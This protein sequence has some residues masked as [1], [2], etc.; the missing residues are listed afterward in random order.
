MMGLLYN[1]FNSYFSKDTIRDQKNFKLMV[2]A[3]VGGQLPPNS[4]GDYNEELHF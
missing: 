4:R 1:S 2:H 3:F